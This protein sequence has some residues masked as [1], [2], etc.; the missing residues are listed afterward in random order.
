MVIIQCGFLV[1]VSEALAMTSLFSQKTDI[2]SDWMTLDNHPENERNII[3]AHDM[4]TQSTKKSSA[5]CAADAMSSGQLMSISFAFQIDRCHEALYGRV[6]RSFVLAFCAACGFRSF[7][8]C[9][10]EESFTLFFLCLLKRPKLLCSAGCYRESENG[11]VKT[12]EH[13]ASMVSSWNAIS[14]LLVMTPPPLP[15][16]SC[17]MRGTGTLHKGFVCLH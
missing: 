5:A 7:D 17:I 11:S 15:L 3:I 1:S 8:S 10:C 14:G 9:L 4:L 13:R 2:G 6:A 16:I 12:C